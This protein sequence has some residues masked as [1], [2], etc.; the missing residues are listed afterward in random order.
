MNGRHPPL[1]ARGQGE[2][3]RDAFRRRQRPDV[4]AGARVLEQRLDLCEKR[5]GQ[6]VVAEKPEVNVLPEELATGQAGT[7]L[8]RR[9]QPPLGVHQAHDAGCRCGRPPD[10]LVDSRIGA[11]PQGVQVT[12]P[13]QVPAGGLAIAGKQVDE[14]EA[15]VQ[16]GVPVVDRQRRRQLAEG[17]REAA[18]RCQPAAAIDRGSPRR[19]LALTQAV[20]VRR[21][22][23]RGV[24]QVDSDGAED[25]GRP[26]SRRQCCDVGQVALELP[27]GALEPRVVGRHP[28]VQEHLHAAPA[29]PRRRPAAQGRQ[30][31]RQK[32]TAA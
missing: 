18:L 1:F 28:A 20:A 24:A 27:V 3:F 7:A 29:R 14:A 9:C 32:L 2:S 11:E 23:R 15:E 13:G 26:G 31:P 19:Q 5:L 6:P 21:R 22:E 12:G 25:H 4:V 8:R 17:L 16:L 10:R 30:A